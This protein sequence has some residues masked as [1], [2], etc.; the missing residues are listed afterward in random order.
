[1]KRTAKTQKAFACA[2]SLAA[3]F[4][5]FAAVASP[6]GAQARVSRIVIETREPAAYAPAGRTYEILR[7]RFYGELDAKASVNADI[8]DI[9][10]A[11]RNAKGL[12]EYSATFAIA[13]PVDPAQASGILWYD[14][15]NRGNFW[16]GPERD[17]HIR[18]ASGWQGDIPPGPNV[19]TATVP[20][21]YAQGHK[22]VSP[23]LVHFSRFPSGSKSLQLVAGLGRGVP[24]PLPDSMDTRRAQLY[25][26]SA[27]DAPLISVPAS[28]WAYAD[29]SAED[30]PG[31]PDPTQIC[32]HGGFDS[33]QAY[34]LVYPARDPLVLGIG[35]AATR[36]L[37]S[38]LRYAKTDDAGAPNPVDGLV[39]NAIGTGTSQS[40]NFLRT[41]LNQGFNGDEQD[42]IVFD[43]INP[44]IAARQIPLN[45]RF[46]VPG[47][48]SFLY[49]AGSD[50][51]V[52]WTDYNDAAR[53]LG[54]TSLLSRCRARK[55]CPKIIETFGS[56]E[57]WDLRMSPDLIGTDAKADLPLPD[58]VRRYYLPSTTHGGGSGRFTTTGDSPVA[59][60]KLP[61]NPIP[62]TETMHVALKAL[63]DW[64]R[65]IALP[66]ASVYPTLAEGD[67]VEANADAMGWPAVPGG[68]TPNGKLNPLYHYD[69]GPGFNYTDVSGVASKLPPRI[70]G[71]L[72]SRVPRV[73]KD[74][75]ETVGVP[76]V[77]LL[78]PLGT[79][80]GWNERAE[81]YGAGGRCYFIGGFIPFERTKAER[82]AKRDP[83]LSLEER[84]GDHAGYVARVKKAVERRINA[85]WLLP[86]DGARL[87]AAAEASDVLALPKQT[88]AAKR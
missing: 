48:A 84:Y 35:F 1:M 28:E 54:T 47:G 16:V 56:A 65:G 36:D 2:R 70:I 87:V 51:A 10:G 50:G 33:L 7:G 59:S 74:G 68:A 23:A 71:V 38:F 4:V 67:L 73:N 20:F 55:V 82:L 9:R 42:R 75:N 86:E 14:V 60:C 31:K 78:A 27:D 5:A 26:Q 69:F 85:G 40:G 66:P 8:T 39:Q 57:F 12:V 11:P 25:R 76:S 19:Q 77:Q 61:G 3:A 80:M 88:V 30:F 24:R 64:V 49:D 21:A 52:W 62:S 29:C 15:P 13:R 22:I 58:N 41:F 72:P 18:V 44:N 45:M 6:L 34:T 17:G 83:R 63:V 81:G 53:G 46:G 37:I 32:L 43:G 79:Y